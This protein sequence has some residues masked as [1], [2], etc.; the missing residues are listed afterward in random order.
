MIKRRDLLQAAAALGAGLGLE[1]PLL[2]AAPED[3]W[4]PPGAGAKNIPPRTPQYP[5]KNARTLRSDAE[6][7]QAR[8]NIA[9]Y[10]AAKSLRDTIV[11][12]A[13]FWLDWSDAD[14][15]T[16]ITPASVPRAFDVGASVGCPKCG[17][18]I[19][20]KFGTYP[21]LVDLRKPF[22]LTCPVDGSV[23]PDND[24][25][26]DGPQKA[27]AGAKV[28]DN[29]YGWLNPENNERY[30]FVAHWNHRMWH[31][32]V[33]PGVNALAQAYQLTGD[34][35]FAHKAAVM[36]VRIAEVYP[37]MD[38]ERQSRFGLMMAQ[39]G[40]RYPGKVIN[41]IWE[42]N[43]ASDFAEAYDS[44]WET[45]DSD[46]PLQKQFGKSG[47]QIRAFVEANLL[48]D[49]IDAYFNE[50]I[51]GNFGMHQ[52]S[53]AQLAVT[54][55]QG[56]QKK[57]LDGLLTRTGP[58]TSYTGFNYALYNLVYRDG[59]PGES[60][61]GYNFLWVAKLAEVS[62][63][64][65]KGGRNLFAQPRMRSIF[66]APLDIVNLRQYTPAWGD[67]GSVYGDPAK[68]STSVYQTAYRAYS[69][70]RYARYLA[71][72]GAAGDKGFLTYA[73]LFAAPIKDSA[74]P[75]PQ[76]ARV[77]AGAGIC[78]LSNRQDTVSATL[79]YGLKA[80]HG[81]FDR[82]SF[83]LFANSQP[84][85][86][87]LGY[88]DAMNEFVAGIF[89]WS[90]N[91]ISH[92]TVTVDASRQTGNAPGTLRLFADSDFARV[93][94]LDGAGTYP[95]AKVYRRALV[96]VDAGAP[97]SYYLDIFDVE[98]GSQHD[99]A[100]HGPPGKFALQGGQWSTPAA[101][102]LAGENVPLGVIYDDAKLGKPGYKE[103]FNSYT[104]SGFQHIYGVQRHTGGD[105]WV[106]EWHHEKDPAARVRIRTL[107][108]S[109][110]QMI[111]GKAHVSPVKFPQEIQLLIARRKDES[112]GKAL[113]SRFISV[114]EPYKATA[115][116][117][118][119]SSVPLTSGS[120]TAVEVKR[121]GGETDL[122]LHDPSQSKKSLG[123]ITSDAHSAMITRDAAGKIRRIFFAGG[124]YLRVGKEEWRSAPLKGTVTA[125]DPQKRTVTVNLENAD[126]AADAIDGRIA[127]FASD[128]RQTA[129]PV[130]SSRRDGSTLTLTT[131]DDL[132]IGRVPVKAVQ[133]SKI[134][135]DVGLPL[136][137][138]YKGTSVCREDFS[139]W[140]TVQE[141][142]GFS[143]TLLAS[144]QSPV[145]GKD[146]WVINV[147][148]GDRFEVPAQFA[149]TM[150][151]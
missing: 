82:L 40:S 143:L 97:G 44:V 135:S 104:G 52:K 98:G 28:I 27:S 7:T 142:S 130:L 19:H 77:L 62:E 88:P 132:I 70:D 102:T 139:A 12:G 75:V 16:L 66:D 145:I 141:A 14:L 46:S 120:G 9:R 100:L 64:L 29:G 121:T 20:E 18:K 90:K 39:K 147:A 126:A 30:W 129:H 110:Q 49:A 128:L 131:K 21:W 24:Y 50:Q 53:L 2:A 137:A 73:S 99:Y 94:D 148:P 4:P 59:T 26:V 31:R 69:E 54:R 136:G 87:D 80:G 23:Y 72:Q 74:T 10:P 5:L 71:S 33:G 67:S 86:P 91:T 127:Q 48:E 89:T 105:D 146:L 15:R 83:E 133:G 55:Q 35:R 117:S 60:A 65:A 149:K 3:A 63:L 61:P 25:V 6:I 32:H 47:E 8:A 37:A 22:K 96:M 56:D 57:W 140:Q 112:G 84:I 76:K 43:L 119:C 13:S 118:A 1:A 124:S 93:V 42:T 116:I 11:K 106:A 113:K 125:V 34:K 101:G 45:I 111:T 134:T 41:A 144:A 95:Q 81:H 114:I 17:L 122:I 68:L 150:E 58:S 92:N 36:L 103:G 108:Q 138:T 78:I 79:N 109:G 38:H 151:S 51:R 107:P 123:E 115:F 85:L